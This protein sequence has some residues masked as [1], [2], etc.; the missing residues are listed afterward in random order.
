MRHALTGCMGMVTIG[1]TFCAA[2][3]GLTPPSVNAPALHLTN[4]YR[5]SPFVC[6][7]QVVANPFI[8]S[9][10][11]RPGQAA[12]FLF[13]EFRPEQATQQ[14]LRDA[15][16]AAVQPAHRAVS[17]VDALLDVMDIVKGVLGAQ[18]RADTYTPCQAAACSSKGPSSHVHCVLVLQW[19]VAHGWLSTAA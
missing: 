15:P 13:G 8:W 12:P 1:G 19:S 6:I 9:R 16:A 10:L 4:F 11:A 7:P 18:V 2:L 3:H 5:R 17:A 14:T